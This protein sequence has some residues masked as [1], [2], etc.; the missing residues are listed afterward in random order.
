MRGWHVRVEEDG[1]LMDPLL[2]LGLAA[3]VAV[4]LV[5][6]S[7]IT[8][9]R[10]TDKRDGVEPEAEDAGGGQQQQQQM[11]RG[12]TLRARAAALRRARANI[13]G[14]EVAEEDEDLAVPE[15][16]E[17]SPFRKIGTK[18]LRKMKDKAE[19]KVMREQEEA[20]REDRKKREA[21]REEEIK[22]AE[23]EEGARKKQEV[24]IL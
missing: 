9:R 18:K 13:A 5:I 17:A 23:A 7:L 11:R 15:E 1:K 10:G 2:W 4:L 19:K 16:E 21:L 24:Y 20:I 6:L 3:V 14:E 8:F 22:S 12:R